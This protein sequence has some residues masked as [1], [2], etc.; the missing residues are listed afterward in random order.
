MSFCIAIKHH[1]H[2]SFETPEMG[3]LYT[4]CFHAVGVILFFD[5]QKDPIWLLWT[6]FWG[7]HNKILDPRD[8][9]DGIIA[10]IVNITSGMIR[11]TCTVIDCHLDVSQTAG[12]SYLNLL[13]NAQKINYFLCVLVY[14]WTI[15]HVHFFRQP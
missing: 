8:L 4:I 9:R 11:L 1:P 2:Y 13:D 3:Q 14:I 7:Y 12:C 15:K 10:N 6:F 5:H